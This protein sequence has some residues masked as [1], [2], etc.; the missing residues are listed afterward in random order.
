MPIVCKVC[1]SL[2]IVCQ[3][4]LVVS[5]VCQLSAKVC[6]L[7]AKVCQSLRVR[8]HGKILMTSKWTINPLMAVGSSD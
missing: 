7:S 1:K 6:Q 8:G 2:Q 4:L 5:K 3:R